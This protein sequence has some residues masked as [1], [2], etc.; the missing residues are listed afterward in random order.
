MEDHNIELV[1][2]ED[3]ASSLRNRL[4]IPAP[5]KASIG[6]CIL[7]AVGRVVVLLAGLGIVAMGVGCIVGANYLLGSGHWLSAIL[8]GLFGVWVCVVGGNVAIGAL[9]PEF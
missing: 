5:E 9:S 6:T 8:L 3:G 4:D 1:P 2:V 7:S